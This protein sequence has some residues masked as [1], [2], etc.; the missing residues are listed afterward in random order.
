MFQ[1]FLGMLLDVD[2]LSSDS[3]RA[4]VITVVCDISAMASDPE[5]QPQQTE[6][7]RE[8]NNICKD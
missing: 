4:A 6:G 2:M 1:A 3:T 5:S 7:P 8:H